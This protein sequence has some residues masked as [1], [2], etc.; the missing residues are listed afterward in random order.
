MFLLDELVVTCRSHQGR[1]SLKRDCRTVD[2]ETRFALKFDAITL[3]KRL[4]NEP[5]DCGFR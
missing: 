2:G 5:L 4:R 3:I 1:K